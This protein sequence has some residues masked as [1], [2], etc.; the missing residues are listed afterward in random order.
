MRGIWAAIGVF[1]VVLVFYVGAQMLLEK[2][3]RDDCKTRGGHIE[4]ITTSRG[5][6]WACDVP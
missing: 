6:A 5:P 2:I 1:A 4:R 3:A